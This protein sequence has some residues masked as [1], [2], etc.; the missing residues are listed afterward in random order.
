MGA[1]RIT[2]L[3]SA[4]F[5]TAT[6]RSGEAPAKPSVSGIQ[7]Q[8]PVY[9]WPT[10]QTDSS[11]LNVLAALTLC[12][13][14]I[15]DSNRKWETWILSFTVIAFPGFVDK[16]K[17]EASRE[18]LFITLPNDFIQA[19]DKG[20]KD[21]DTNVDEV[22]LLFPLHLP[23]TTALFNVDVAQCAVI[24]GVYGYLSLVT[25]FMGRTV[26]PDNVDG[27]TNRRPGNIMDAIGRRDLSYI[28]DG[29]GKIGTR[30]HEMIPLAWGH[31]VAARKVF[32]S[33][34]CT[35]TEGTEQAQVV[36]SVLL[37]LMEHTGMQPAYLIHKLLVALPWVPQVALLRP[38]YEVY[39]RSVE[40]FVRE[41]TQR[42][43][44]AKL[45]RGP[46]HR[47]FHAPSMANL[48][49][50]AKLWLKQTAPSL[51]AYNAPGNEAVRLTF[52]DE[53]AK[54]GTPLLDTTVYSAGAAV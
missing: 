34:Y 45:I 11:R 30:G 1:E 40:A 26:T 27:F 52:A 10:G 50:C 7:R 51:E 49:Y 18:Y 22:L 17:A 16:L 24:P 6:Y 41:P 9:T 31:A 47:L 25:F 38:D 29:P 28:L 21:L 20:V 15:D 14:S 5:D 19:V 12:G 37:R 8:V 43:P 42:R 54:H 46:N 23:A 13:Q 48:T 53:C 35:F 44:Y 3:S 33:E 4:V 39:A 2:A 36:M 32:L